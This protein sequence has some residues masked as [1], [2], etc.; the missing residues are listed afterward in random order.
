MN[1]RAFPKAHLRSKWAQRAQNA[2]QGHSWRAA[3]RPR[4]GKRSNG[5]EKKPF[6]ALYR[7][8][9]GKRSNGLEKKPF[10]ALYRPRA[11]KRS[12]GLEKK[13][14]LA[15]YRIKICLSEPA[16]F[17][18][19][20]SGQHNRAG[21]AAALQES[22]PAGQVLGALRKFSAKICFGKTRHSAGAL[23]L[24]PTGDRDG[25]RTPAIVQRKTAIL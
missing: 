10:L 5:L 15:L 21:R 4:A 19:E 1:G 17:L 8:R 16:V 6:L 13:P 23:P 2:P 9:A 14:F 24:H 11:G 25:P 7:P 18:S 22:A 3:A 20:H 12:N